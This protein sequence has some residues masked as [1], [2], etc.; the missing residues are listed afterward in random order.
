[1]SVPPEAQTATIK[2]TITDNS[3]NP[4]SGMAVTVGGYFTDTTGE[5][6][7]YEVLS[8]E[9]GV[10]SLVTMRGSHWTN[11][12]VAEGETITKDFILPTLFVR[13]LGDGRSPVENV[14][15][16]IDGK[17]RHTGQEG[18]VSMAV[19]ELKSYKLLAQNEYSTEI[20]FMGM[21]KKEDGVVLAP[22]M[23]FGGLSGPGDGG[24]IPPEKAIKVSAVDV[25]T[26]EPVVG[27]DVVAGDEKARSLTDR[28]GDAT[29]FIR[30]VDRDVPVALA[31]DDDRYQEKSF[32][33]G[34]EELNVSIEGLPD[35]YETSVELVRRGEISTH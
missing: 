1:M 27:C 13:V 11:V 15:V 14:P 7:K 34:K 6:G 22:L 21:A 10:V 29:L 16:A 32:M 25:E 31:S 17:T 20:F 9:T 3:G 35:A 23:P 8:T 26:G 33:I 5:D 24:S 30:S 18:Q 28:N 2:G 4:V 12:T 19:R